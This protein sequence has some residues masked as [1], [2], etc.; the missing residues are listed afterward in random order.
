VG[1]KKLVR[2]AELPAKRGI[3]W[4]RW[5][6]FRGMSLRD[7]LQL[8]IVPFA[9]VA[10]GFVFTVQQDARLQKIENQRAEAERDL[11]EQRAQNE[12]L[13]AYLN[14]MSELILERNLLQT[15][16]EESD[17]IYALAQARTST[18][19]LALDAEHNR[20]VIRF[21]F[22]AGLVAGDES[23]VS[24]LRGLSVENAQL[25]EAWLPEANLEYVDLNGANLSH[26]T[27][28]AA[29][30]SDASLRGADLSYAIMSPGAD[31]RWA[32][33]TNAKLN[34]T[35]MTGA[36]LAN[37]ILDGADLKYT[38]LFLATGWTEEQLAAAESLA[39]ATMPD[40]QTLQ[41]FDN[42]VGPTF[43][44][45]FKSKGSGRMDRTAAHRNVCQSDL[46]R[47]YV[48]RTRM[49]KAP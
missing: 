16:D 10:I 1:R 35:D 17:P 4:P 41:T 39:G 26:A 44:Q 12:A 30:L 49:N 13:Q 29:D 24:L 9:V 47:I 11:A 22:D 32:D 46:P 21:L 33:L 45:W 2:K 15:E 23:S 25:S 27:L 6:G 48:P 36:N 19:L 7:W 14:Q 18:V 28:N 34:H 3:A 43:E 8:L 5:T 38:R 37:A 20:S 31:L 40:G 42:P